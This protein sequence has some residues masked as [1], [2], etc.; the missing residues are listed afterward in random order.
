MN[1][2]KSWKEQTKALF[3]IEK[4]KIGENIRNYRHIKKKC[5]KIYTLSERVSK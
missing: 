4:L 2:F 5:I 3:F 1:N